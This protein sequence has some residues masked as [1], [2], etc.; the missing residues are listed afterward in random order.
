[1]VM[2]SYIHILSV[3]SPIIFFAHADVKSVKSFSKKHFIV[4]IQLKLN[5]CM[6]HSRP[7]NPD[8][9]IRALKSPDY[10]EIRS[11]GFKE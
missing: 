1:M 11:T 4:E 6:L 3:Q 10:K 5:S 8:Y 7:L 2:T 9:W